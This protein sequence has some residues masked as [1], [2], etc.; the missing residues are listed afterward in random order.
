MRINSERIAPA[1]S[2]YKITT[3]IDK[4][5]YQTGSDQFLRSGDDTQ[6]IR[7]YVKGLELPIIAIDVT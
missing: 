3:Q 6:M 2:A 7:G 5:A 1:R 4:R